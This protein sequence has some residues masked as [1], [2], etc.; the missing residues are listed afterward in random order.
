[1]EYKGIDRN[2]ALF[3]ARTNKEFALHKLPFR[4]FIFDTVIIMDWR[5]MSYNTWDIKGGV[6][7]PLMNTVIGRLVLYET[8]LALQYGLISILDHCHLFNITK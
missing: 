3:E 2:W 8:G 7:G 6:L 1:M 4:I 5:K